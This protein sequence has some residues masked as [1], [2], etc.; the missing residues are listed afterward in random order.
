MIGRIEWDV[1]LWTYVFYYNDEKHVLNVDSIDDAEQ[2]ADIIRIK[3]EKT[4]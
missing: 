4:D 3:Y 1:E 2:R